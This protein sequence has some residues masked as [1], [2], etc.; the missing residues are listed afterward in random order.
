MP[1]LLVKLVESANNRYQPVKQP[2]PAS[3]VKNVNS[4]NSQ[5]SPHNSVKNLGN[6]VLDALVIFA[7]FSLLSH[8][9]K[10]KQGRNLMQIKEMKNLK[11]IK[12][13]I[14]AKGRQKVSYIG[15]NGDNLSI[16]DSFII[17][18]RGLVTG[19][20]IETLDKL[21]NERQ[22]RYYKGKYSLS[23]DLLSDPSLTYNPL[24]FVKELTIKGDKRIIKDF[25][26]RVIIKKIN[27][28]FNKDI[29]SI[30]TKEYKNL[31]SVDEGKFFF[32]EP[33]PSCKL[34]KNSETIALYNKQNKPVGTMIEFY[35]VNSTSKPGIIRRIITQI[36]KATG[37]MKKDF[38]EKDAKV[39]YPDS[40]TRYFSD[41]PIRYYF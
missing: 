19:R 7:V 16:K 34:V 13:E 28:Y 37:K 5:E 1:D 41:A 20:L 27:R 17:D 3:Y 21:T 12:K 2:A 31:L 29:E 4:Q 40:I 33:N 11:N 24:S 32:Y 9:F 39:P 36:D 35:D 15:N 26:G 6:L 38:L 14:L 8:L 10:G 18:K 22:C 23:S 25:K 30:E